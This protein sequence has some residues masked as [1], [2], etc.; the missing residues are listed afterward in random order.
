MAETTRDALREKRAQLAELK[1]ANAEKQNELAK[2]KNEEALEKYAKSLDVDIAYEEWASSVLNG[3][4]GTPPKEVAET[5]LTPPNN[6]SVEQ[7][8]LGDPL[9]PNV[10]GQGDDDTQEGDD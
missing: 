4:D 3:G 9:V 5:L 1:R 2:A 10:L 6:S 7:Q 8:R